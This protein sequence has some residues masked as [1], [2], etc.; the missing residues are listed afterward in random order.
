MTRSL[1]IIAG[2]RPLGV[3]L[4]EGEEYYFCTCGRSKNQPFCDGSHSTTTFV[5]QAFTAEKDG[6]AYL[7]SCKHSLNQPFCDGSHKPF[8]AEQIGTEGPGVESD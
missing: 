3:S 7:C 8:A 6:M 2:N 4:T 1:P 5:P